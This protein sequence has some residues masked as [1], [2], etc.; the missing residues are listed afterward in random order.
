MQYAVEN[1]ASALR[2]AK[3]LVATHWEDIRDQFYGKDFALN[4]RVYEQLEKNNQLIIVT[5][6]SDTGALVGFTFCVLNRNTY[7]DVVNAISDVIY[8]APHYRVSKIFIK[9]IGIL[10]DVL[11]NMNVYDITY[12]VN[13]VN[14]YSSILNRLDYDKQAIV[15]NKK[16]GDD[17]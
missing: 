2:D 17:I 9:L 12:N 14:D 7:C 5:A 6:R 1:V 11:S 10:E 13:L 3:D 8:V 16:I 4:D 15:F